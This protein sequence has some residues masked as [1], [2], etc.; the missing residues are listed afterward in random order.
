MICEIKISFKDINRLVIAMS[1]NNNKKKKIKKIKKVE[2]RGMKIVYPFEER[3]P[4]I[5]IFS[6]S[7][8]SEMNEEGVSVRGSLK[9]S[10][11]SRNLNNSLETR[12]P[13]QS[14]R[15][16]A[17]ARRKARRED[18]F[19][20]LLLVKRAKNFFVGAWSRWIRASFG[21]G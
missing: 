5:R 12:S 2:P 15:V 14:R 3:G 4:S 9:L 7:W 10:I 6:K 19:L 18:P 16:A 13:V 20:P 8:R 17:S 21:P 11:E 1:K